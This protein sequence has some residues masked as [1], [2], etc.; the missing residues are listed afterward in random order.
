MNASKIAWYWTL[1]K[2]ITVSKKKDLNLH[3]KSI[4]STNNLINYTKLLKANTI[5]AYVNSYNPKHTH[6]KLTHISLQY[7]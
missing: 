3:L 2:T 4:S 1:S 6:T 5:I 7:F